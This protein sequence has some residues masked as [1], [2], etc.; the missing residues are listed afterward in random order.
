MNE[1]EN[2]CFWVIG[3]LVT[4]VAVFGNA[5]V[6]YLIA[7]KQHLQN[8]IN[9]IILSLA[10]ADLLV[11]LTFIPLF[12]TCWQLYSCRTE[13]WLVTRQAI[14]WTFL[15]ASVSNLFI[16]TVDRYVAVTSPLKHKRVTTP[17]HIARLV[18]TAWAIPIITRVF[19]FIPI[20]LKAKETALK[21]LVPIFLFIFEVVPCVLLPCFT[22]RMVHIVRKNQLARHKIEDST[23]A[24]TAPSLRVHIRDDRRKLNYGNVSVVVSVVVFF[25]ICY[26]VELFTSI[27]NIFHLPLI[28]RSTWSVRHI[29]LVTN[30]ALNP[31]AYAIFKRDIKRAI[32][33]LRRTPVNNQVLS[34]LQ[35][36]R[37]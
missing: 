7:T 20:F 9:W 1:K 33:A 4:I 12:H 11:G 5:L 21:Y 3:W 26:S 14:Q 27:C 28:S 29:L 15:Y 37:H 6:I 25:T 24:L 30:S 16:M 13:V 35:T 17:T 34:F 19:I 32:L 23:I 22:S 2:L 10:S 18:L 31:I 8:G 36:E